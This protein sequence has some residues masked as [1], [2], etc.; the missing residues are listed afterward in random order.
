MIQIAQVLSTLAV[1]RPV[2]HSEADFQHALAWEIHSCVPTPLQA[3][4]LRSLRT[5]SGR[6]DPKDADYR[7]QRGICLRA[8]AGNAKMHG[9]APGDGGYERGK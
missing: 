7:F 8:T 4:F 1:Q 6:S 5:G 9:A 3:P 2:F